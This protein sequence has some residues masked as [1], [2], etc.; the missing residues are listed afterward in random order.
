MGA[1]LMSL[2]EPYKVVRVT[3]T[4]DTSAYA[5]G[6]VLFVATE[7]PNAVNRK[8]GCSKLIGAY[9]LSQVHGNADDFDVYFHTGNTSLGTINAT[10]NIDDDDIQF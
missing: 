6:D 9:C 3:P 2:N 4:L 1:S 5:Q 8:G 10:A 7:L